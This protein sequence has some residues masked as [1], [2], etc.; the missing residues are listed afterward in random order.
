MEPSNKLEFSIHQDKEFFREVI[1]YTS[2]VTGMNSL[3]VEK[4]YY[5]SMI[6]EYLFRFKDS[7]LVFKGGTCI[8]KVYAAFYRM[9]EDLDFSISVYPDISRS[10]RSKKM[11]PVKQMFKNFIRDYDCFIYQ[12]ELKGFNQSTQYIGKLAYES[13]VGPSRN[14]GLI[15]F[16][17]SLREKLI[18]EPCK[19]D[20]ST[21]LIDPFQEVPVIAFFNTKVPTINELYAE[22][23]RAA[24]SRKEP[25]IRDFYDIFFAMNRLE[26]DFLG[27]KFINLVRTKLAV[28]GNLPVD[29]S[30]NKKKVLQLQIDTELKPVLRSKDFQQFDFEKAF[31]IVEK[32]GKY[33]GSEIL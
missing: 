25:A 24:L 26:M 13:V 27:G 12:D 22:K 20:T 2:S 6:L 16:E 31:R 18:E 19:R 29:M 7:E 4:D 21:I 14:N 30:V 8:S 3:L 33:T 28:Q 1:L 17:I 9:S 5:C 10:E 15:K 32:V 23:F 11:E